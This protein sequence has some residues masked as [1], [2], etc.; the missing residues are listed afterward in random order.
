MRAICMAGCSGRPDYG[1]HIAN[2]FLPPEKTLITPRERW[3]VEN[4]PWKYGK[5]ESLRLGSDT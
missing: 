5:E 1:S 4:F 2:A 3:L